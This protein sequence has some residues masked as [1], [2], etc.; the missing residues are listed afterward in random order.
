[1]SHDEINNYLKKYSHIFFDLDDTIFPLSDYDKGAFEEVSKA[2][3]YPELIEKGKNWLLDR[4]S[5]QIDDRLFKNFLQHFALPLELEL[6]C[7]EVYQS[8][9]CWTMSSANSLYNVIIKLKLNNKKL[10]L[11]TNGNF[12][13]QMRKLDALELTDL[14]DFISIGDPILTPELMKPGSKLLDV[15]GINPLFTKCIMVGD[16]IGIDGGFAKN[17]KIEFLNFK[18]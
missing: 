16:N 15:L 8:F 10:Y 18:Y 14:F 6:K 17:S 9:N 11:V 1:M 4:K 13:R 2:V 3:L 7:V 5:K 12:N